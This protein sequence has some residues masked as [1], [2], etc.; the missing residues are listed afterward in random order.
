MWV[1]R[2][3]PRKN[4]HPWHR[5]TNPWWVAGRGQKIIIIILCWFFFPLNLFI[6]FLFLFSF[7][8][9]CHISVMGFTPPSHHHLDV[10]LHHHHSHH[11][12]H[13]TTTQHNKGQDSRCM[14]ISSPRFFHMFFLNFLFCLF[15]NSFL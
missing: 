7:S 10:C 11:H 3:Q 1:G 5:F 8:S 13:Q 4:L 14:R 6:S 12:H 9:Q 2:S 15:T